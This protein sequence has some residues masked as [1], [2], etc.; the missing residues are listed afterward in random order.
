MK[1]NQGPASDEEPELEPWWISQEPPEHFLPR[2][3]Q[4]HKTA[5]S[6]MALSAIVA[7]ISY[8]LWMGITAQ[9]M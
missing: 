4:R 3:L 5:L 6:L 2:Q 9:S 8:F 7:F 1:E